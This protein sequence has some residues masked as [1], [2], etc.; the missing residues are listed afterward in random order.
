VRSTGWLAAG[1]R[2]LLFG[3]V[4]SLREIPTKSGNR[5][6]FATIEDTDGTVD[7]TI[8]PEPFK[9]AAAH[10]RSRDALLVRGR[11]DDT[12]KGRVVLAEEVRLLEHALAAGAGRGPNGHAAGPPNACRVRVPGAG[13][14]GT[15]LSGLHR[16]CDEHAGGVPL[17]VHVLVSS[18]EVVV[19]AGGVSVDGS[20]DLV[21]KIEALL[22]PG[23]CTVEHAGRA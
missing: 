21:T 15:L 22:G 20:P 11:I 14:V 8:F 16:V 17:F 10:L 13:D 18:L 9:A 7:I 19:R 2:V 23:A 3:Q 4:A 12:E 5:M 6:A 1:S